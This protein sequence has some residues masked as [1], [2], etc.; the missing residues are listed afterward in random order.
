[1]RKIYLKISEEIVMKRALR[2]LKRW[3]E[4]EE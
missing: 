2:R 4:Y 3:T 1:M